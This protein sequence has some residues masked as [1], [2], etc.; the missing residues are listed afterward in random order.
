M[1][2]QL[3]DGFGCTMP[4]LAVRWAKKQQARGTVLGVAEATACAARLQLVRD[5][6]GLALARLAAAAAAHEHVEN[7]AHATAVVV[8]ALI[9]GI[10]AVLV[11]DSPGDW[12][13]KITSVSERG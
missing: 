9:D 10:L 1:T 3:Y 13:Q 12:L 11:V 7:V 2:A 4:R 8:H 5:V 6:L